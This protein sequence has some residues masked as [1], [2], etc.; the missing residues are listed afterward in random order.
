MKENPIV[1]RNKNLITR[2]CS[3]WNLTRRPLLVV[4]AG[5]TVL[6]QE[7]NLF[8]FDFRGT[9]AFAGNTVVKLVYARNGR[10]I[11]DMS[12]DCRHYE[13]EEQSVMEFGEYGT[14]G[15]YRQ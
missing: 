2:Y 6:L 11:A 15:T 13:N 3:K 5:N 8:R 10:I 9:C 7:A 14:H 12:G 4:V 1:V